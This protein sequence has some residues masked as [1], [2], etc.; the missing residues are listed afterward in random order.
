MKIHFGGRRRLLAIAALLLAAL[1]GAAVL[2]AR[3]GA[4]ASPDP[5]ITVNSID[6]TDHRDAA[7]TLREA[8]KLAT[9]DLHLGDLT[10]AECVRVSGAQWNS[11]QG[12]KMLSPFI[13]PPPGPS[14]PDTI[15]FDPAMFPPASPA[16][17]DIYS[18][19]PSLDTGND[20]IDGSSVGVIVSGGGNWAFN[21]FHIQMLSGGNTIKG[22][23]ISNCYTAVD[24]WGH[25][26]TIG[27][28]G[29]GEG[30]VISGS[31]VGVALNQAWSNSVKGNFIGTDAAHNITGVIISAAEDNTI[32]G[33]GP[34][35]GNVISGNEAWGIAM[36]FLSHGNR[37][38]GN[39]IGTDAAGAA[40]VPNWGGVLMVPYVLGGPSAN[41]I[42]GSGPGEGN[43]ISGNEGRGIQIGGSCEGN[44]IVGNYI[45][46]DATGT[47]AVPNGE[48]G[49]LIDG[50]EANTIGGSSP[51]EGNVIAFNQGDGV[52]LYGNARR[53]TISGNSIHSNGGK[54]I[55]NLALWLARP[56]VWIATG[57]ASGGTD[58]KCYPC[59]VEVFSDDEDEGRI[60]HGSTMTENDAFGTWTYAGTVTG[61]YVTAT[62]TDADGNTSEFS[63]PVAVTT[64]TP[65]PTPTPTPTG[66][67]TPTPTRTV[68]PTPTP[69]VG[70]TR[71]VVWGSGWHNE[72]WSGASTPEEAFACAA[73][74]YAAAYRLVNGAW[75]RYFPDRPDLSNMRPL[76]QY[77]AFLI[78]ITQDVT[79]T[80]PVAA[81][82]GAT[83]TLQWSPGWHNEGWSGPDGTTPEVAF[84]CAA[85]NYAAAYRFVDGGLERFFPGRPE[86]SN[87]GPLNKYD[88]FLVLVTAPVSCAM[89]I[90]S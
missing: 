1:A 9:G 32:G 4:E 57:S 40:A 45:G 62:I 84:A 69:P 83:R 70:P 59:T 85:G 65:T 53:I 23:Q 72:T 35:E 89:P 88:A 82:P 19:L 30:N 52:R 28:S 64:A 73:G 25:H 67:V 6:D 87:M 86:I 14:S 20:T 60:Y 21:C 54:G 71:T 50:A 37:V 74:S 55:E 47:A 13:N 63:A 79:C 10:G 18:V 75:E 3:P 76:G 42:G 48:E 17:I 29:P 26:N 80:M 36:E 22:L 7:L 38:M 81:A 24:V 2:L 58:P 34:G 27:G 43:V 51:G 44:N 77:D 33:S 12:C 68:T 61:P 41:T 31:R 11:A 16:T 39:Y 15:V 49:V 78:L 90:A 66:S 56:Y 5:T 8:I 46:S